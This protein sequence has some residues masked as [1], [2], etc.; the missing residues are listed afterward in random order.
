M[1]VNASTSVSGG[2][3]RHLRWFANEGPGKKTRRVT[4]I[5]FY[6][7]EE[8]LGFGQRGTRCR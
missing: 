3:F 6:L 5:I 4:S 2:D 7:G 1:E 8:K